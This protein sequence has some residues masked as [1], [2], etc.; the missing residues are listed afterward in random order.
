MMGRLAE[1]VGF[2]LGLVIGVLLLPF[3][4]AAARVTTTVVKYESH[5]YEHGDVV[6]VVTSNRLTGSVS[7]RVY[8]DD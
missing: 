3:W 5:D 7:R 6:V 4:F 8:A 1:V 2:I